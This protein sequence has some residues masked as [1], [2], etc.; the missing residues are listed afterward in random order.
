MN[1]E[2]RALRGLL[3]F[4]S[5]CWRWS[6]PQLT[7]ELLGAVFDDHAIEHRLDRLS[8]F[9]R[10][11]SNGFELQFEFVIWAAFFGIEDQ[12]I[13]GDREC[14]RKFANDFERGLCGA[15]LVA[16][17]LGQMH[18][19][20][21]GQCVL[22]EVL[23]FTQRSEALWEGHEQHIW[24]EWCGHSRGSSRSD[25]CKV[26]YMLLEMHHI[27]GLTGFDLKDGFGAPYSR[28]IPRSRLVSPGR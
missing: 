20:Q 24:C 14:K 11:L 13:A 2:A 22:G 3:G 16:L 27:H 15:A 5:C 21:I 10:K 19:D 25:A 9:G 26:A 8:I 12:R 18:A 1:Q 7:D 17:N 4:S 28:N 6:C 23:I